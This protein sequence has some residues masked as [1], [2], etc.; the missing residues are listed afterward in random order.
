MC[1]PA[2]YKNTKFVKNVNA[3]IQKKPE[4]MVTDFLDDAR[5]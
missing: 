2:I 3:D 5:L 1:P 4:Y